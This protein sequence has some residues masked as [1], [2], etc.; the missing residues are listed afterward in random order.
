MLSIIFKLFGSGEKG[1]EAEILGKKI[2]DLEN[3]VKESILSFS[4]RNIV[5]PWGHYGFF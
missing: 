4:Y 1:K 5:G 2:N 3:D